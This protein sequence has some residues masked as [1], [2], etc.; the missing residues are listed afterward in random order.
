MRFTETPIHGA[1]IIDPSPHIDERGRFM[2]AWC[3]REFAAHG[4]KFVPVQSNMGLSKVAGT[5]RGLHYQVAPAAEAKLVRCTRG[6]VFDMLVDLRK[7]SS[8]FG[9]WTGVEL[10]SENARMLFVPEMCAHGYQTLVDDAE[11]HYMT[12]AHYAPASVRGLNI[13]DPDVAIRWPLPI[14]PISD[15]D[16]K[17]P[18]LKE[19]QQEV[20]DAS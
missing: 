1:W 2:R 15:Q 12:S 19:F 10:S 7:G 5:V 4:I 17:W 16:Q 8:T 11:I 14:G 3:D 13:R 6:T 9:A 20:R 18:S